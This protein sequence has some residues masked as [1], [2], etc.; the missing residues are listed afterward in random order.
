MEDLLEMCIRVLLKKGNGSFQ[1]LYRF[2]NDKRNEDL[3][4]FGKNS[5][6]PLESEFFNDDFETLSS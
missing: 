5:L 2:L 4:V 3:V 1:E 6:N